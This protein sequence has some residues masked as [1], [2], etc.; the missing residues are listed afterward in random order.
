MSASISMNEVKF[1]TIHFIKLTVVVRLTITC[2]IGVIV[3]LAITIAADPI[4]LRYLMSKAKAVSVS[5]V[6]VTSIT[7]DHQLR[8]VIKLAHIA[9]VLRLFIYD[10]Q[11]III[12]SLLLVFNLQYL[13]LSIF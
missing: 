13:R 1:F 3:Y 2:F 6:I 12:D 10:Q 8:L 7:D 5:N 9:E 4:F 11:A